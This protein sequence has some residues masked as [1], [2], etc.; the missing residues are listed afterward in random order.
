MKSIPKLGSE[1][2]DNESEPETGTRVVSSPSR[3]SQD[4]TNIAGDI[5]L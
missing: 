5:M 3:V 1:D 4:G 2:S